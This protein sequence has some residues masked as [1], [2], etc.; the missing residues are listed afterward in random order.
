MDELV[1]KIRDLS[2]E[3]L[4]RYEENLMVGGGTPG[5]TI[6]SGKGVRLF[7]DD[8]KS[9]IDCTSQSW[10]MYLGF[11]NEEIRQTV[12][13]HMGTLSHIHQG[14]H[15]KQRFALAHKLASIAPEHLNRVSFTA[16][17]SLAVEAAM[18]IALKNVPGS[19]MFCSLWDA[20]HGSS[21]NTSGASWIATK[22][23]GNFTGQKNFLAG[24]NTNFVRLP[25]PYCYRCPFK[26]EVETC[27]I[28][29]AEFSALMIQ[30]GVAGP[31]AGILI[32]PVQASGGQIPLP[33]KYLQ[34]MRQI[35]DEFG[36]LLIFD[37][38][39]TYL[40]IGDWFGSTYYDVEPDIIVLGKG[41]GAGSPIAAVIIH[42]RLEGFGMGAEELHT[43]AN[44]SVSQITALKQLEIVERD[45]ILTNT[46]VMGKRIA[47][48]L[49]GLKEKYPVIGDVRQV[50]LHVGAE[51]IDPVTGGNM[52]TGLAVKIRDTAIKNGMILG[53]G[54]VNK[55]LLKFKPPLIVSADEVDEIIDIFDRTLKELF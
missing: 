37:E 46:N 3:E 45:D 33:K 39:Q 50:G 13:D 25:N 47:D 27:G 18:K 21:L 52:E 15:T 20:Y 2:K 12:Y 55:A 35:A 23:N 30:K 41:L 14:F 6:V 31:L 48:G 8:G 42:D 26:K 5:P 51:M 10:A 43:F 49:N 53:T 36:A 11:A 54:G 7:D 44:N 4:V 38:I 16:G 28:E 19:K 34:R 40:R 1:S 17:G 22:S 9:Y 32:E 29:C 24:M